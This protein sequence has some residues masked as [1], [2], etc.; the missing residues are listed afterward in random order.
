MGAHCADHPSPEA[1]PPP[2]R[3][4]A[5]LSSVALAKEDAS[6]LTF[7]F[8]QVPQPFPFCR[9]LY[10]IRTPARA[11]ALRTTFG[12]GICANCRGLSTFQP[13]N[14][15]T[16]AAQLFNFSTGSAFQAYTVKHIQKGPALLSHANTAVKGDGFV[17]FAKFTPLTSKLPRNLPRLFPLIIISGLACEGDQELDQRVGR[18][19]IAV[20]CASDIGVVDG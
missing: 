7:L 4:A 20:D 18:R 5:Y 2:S 12:R 19:D 16:G 9:V 1:S 6:P 14:F 11:S 15:S 8:S 13:F 10:Q 3:A 17:I